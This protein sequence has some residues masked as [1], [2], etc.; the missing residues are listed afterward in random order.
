[1]GCQACKEDQT[2][3]PGD[4]LERRDIKGL[5]GLKRV[6]TPGGSFADPDYAKVQTVNTIN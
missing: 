4:T 1:M 2:P 3:T 6:D 5:G